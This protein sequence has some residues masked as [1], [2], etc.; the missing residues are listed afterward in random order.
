LEPLTL[1]QSRLESS[2]TSDYRL[3]DDKDAITDIS[4]LMLHRYEAGYRLHTLDRNEAMAGRFSGYWR[5]YSAKSNEA[6]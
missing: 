1:Q 3:E 4:A 5:Q 2:L 6:Q